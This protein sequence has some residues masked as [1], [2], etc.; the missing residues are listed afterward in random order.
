VDVQLDLATQAHK[1]SITVTGN[2]FVTLETYHDDLQLMQLT[3]ADQYLLLAKC[4]RC[5][6]KNRLYHS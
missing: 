2:G 6:G 1:S 3:Q 4:S 5:M